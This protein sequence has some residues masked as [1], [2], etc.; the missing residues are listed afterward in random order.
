M[1]LNELFYMVGFKPRPVRYG[2]MIE[3]VRLPDDG[4]VQYARWQH[5]EARV[6]SPDPQLI[7]HWRGLLTPGDV[8]IDVGAHVGDSTLP[9]ALAVGATGTVL[10]LE[11]NPY[12]FPT[13]E[14]TA[15]LNRDKTNIV[16]ICVAATREDAP[17]EMQFGERGYCNGGIHEGISRWIHGSAYTV[18][19][20]GRNL[21]RLLEHEYGHLIPRLRLMKIDT[22]GHDLAVLETVESVVRRQRPLLHVEF[23]NAKKSP[24]GYRRRLFGFLTNL[25]YEV[26]RIDEG[27]ETFLIERIS[28]ANLFE[29]RSF[30]AVC[31]P[32]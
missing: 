5:P 18:M 14:A 16:P 20:Q 32:A 31:L 10:A 13:L 1:K 23:F 2:F 6:P 9:I 4:E 30:D 3:Q 21:A 17:V 11:P 12:V 27:G 8:A 26:W 19:V 7:R 29:H 24:P 22:E 15:A 28:G 25:G